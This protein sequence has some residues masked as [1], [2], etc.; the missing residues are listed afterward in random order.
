MITVGSD[1]IVQPFGITLSRESR[2]QL[3]ATT[4]DINEEKAY[5]DGDI[6]FGTELTNGEWVLK[7]IIEVSTVA[8]RYTARTTLAGQLLDCI[9]SQ[10]LYFDDNPS[11]Y[12]MARLTGKPE[13]VEHPLWIE[14]S[15][16]FSID[17]FWYSLNEN[18]LTGTGVIV[19]AGTFET[20]I[21]VEVNG[22]VTNPSISVGNYV[23]AYSSSVASGQILIIDT[24]NQTAYISATTPINAMANISGS[25]DYMLEPQVSVTVTPSI[26]TATVK[27]NDAWI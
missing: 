23:I 13:I 9:E 14:I 21:L 7:G 4:R 17:P 25:I 5:A 22:P 27:W 18:S 15:I 8:A 26:S 24:G 11:M 20:P 1:G 3:L 19:N 2:Q 10:E 12:T 6:D 16:T